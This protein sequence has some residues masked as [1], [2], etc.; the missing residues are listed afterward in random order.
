[1]NTL[2]S[3]AEWYFE[4]ATKTELE[5]ILVNPVN[6]SVLNDLG[7]DEEDYDKVI[8]LALEYKLIEEALD[9]RGL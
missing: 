1:M 8:S 4:Y 6:S 7:I 5:D 9:V 2:T 3:L